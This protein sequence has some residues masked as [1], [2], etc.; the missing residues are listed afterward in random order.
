M[1]LL[2]TSPPNTPDLATF[3]ALACTEIVMFRDKDLEKKR[4]VDPSQTY[5]AVLGD[6]ENYLKGSAKG[7]D[8][9]NTAG[10]SKSNSSNLPTR[11]D[12]PRFLSKG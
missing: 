3:L 5:E 6:F 4:E 7:N 9:G 12:T 10:F 11:E 2:R 8:A 1:L